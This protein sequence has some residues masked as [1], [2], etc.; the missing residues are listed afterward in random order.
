MA[1]AD[2]SDTALRGGFLDEAFQ[3]IAGFQN[4]GGVRLPSCLV[5]FSRREPALFIQKHR[6]DAHDKRLAALVLACQVPA[7]HFI[8]D[9]Q[10][11]LMRTIRTF[12]TRMRSCSARF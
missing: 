11:A 1:V 10:P 9:R 4:T 6:I 12:E 5:G 8:R 2:T 7:D 3:K